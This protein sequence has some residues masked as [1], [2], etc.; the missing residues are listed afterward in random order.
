MR[1]RRSDVSEDRSEVQQ[2]APMQARAPLFLA[3]AMRG[4]TAGLG[5]SG[6]VGVAV[7]ALAVD[8]ITAMPG[9]AR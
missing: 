8:G 1:R 5:R 3:H 6:R 7:R 2:A 9:A 4:G